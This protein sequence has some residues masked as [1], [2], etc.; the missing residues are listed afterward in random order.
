MSTL[1]KKHNKGNIIYQLTIEDIQN[2]AMQELNRELSPNEIESIIDKVAENINWY[3][4]ISNAI[5]LN[6][7]E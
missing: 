5:L 3:D 2:V 7:K 4:S 6:I 1:L